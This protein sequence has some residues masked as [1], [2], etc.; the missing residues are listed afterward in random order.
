[1]I[2]PRANMGELARLVLDTA[3]DPDL[4]SPRQWSSYNCVPRVQGATPPEL[5]NAV[6]T[7]AVETW[8]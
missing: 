7:T 4:G 2:G 8:G 6:L 3:T 1:L 5:A